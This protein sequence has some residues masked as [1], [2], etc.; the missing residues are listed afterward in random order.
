MHQLKWEKGGNKAKS[1]VTNCMCSGT[2]FCFVIASCAQRPK[3]C[4]A[5]ICDGSHDILLQLL[6]DTRITDNAFATIQHFKRFYMIPVHQPT[7][8]QSPT[9]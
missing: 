5:D 1:A 4:T 8:P 7:Q 6:V 3:N 2:S 9:L